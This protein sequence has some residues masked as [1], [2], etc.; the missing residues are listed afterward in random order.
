MIFAVS[1]FAD[2][3]WKVIRMLFIVDCSFHLIIP[4]GLSEFAALSLFKR[5]RIFKVKTILL[6]L[7]VSSKLT[8]QILNSQKNILSNK[9][10]SCVSKKC[11]KTEPKSK[12]PIKFA[13]IH[14][15]DAWIKVRS[16]KFN[17]DAAVSGSC[18]ELMLSMKEHTTTDRE[19]ISRKM[20][21]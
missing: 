6:W 7:S 10:I 11:P 21:I 15:R 20:F 1:T 3:L 9:F 18:F 19:I 12:N 16:I 8:A 4:T 17:L 14:R 13:D 2:R 5:P